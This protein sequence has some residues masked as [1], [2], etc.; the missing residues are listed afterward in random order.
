VLETV[1]F[2]SHELL[3]AHLPRHVLC[4][5]AAASQNGPQWC[6]LKTGLFNDVHRAIDY[7]FEGNQITTGDKTEPVIG[8]LQFDSSAQYD[9]QTEHLLFTPMF[10]ANNARVFDFE[11]EAATGFHSMRNACSS[12]RP[13]MAQTTAASRWSTPMRLSYTTN[14]FCGAE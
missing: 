3:I 1:R 8:T 13:Q 2:D 4:Y 7:M 9:K 12:R 11:M 14:G 10:K 5:D 6:I